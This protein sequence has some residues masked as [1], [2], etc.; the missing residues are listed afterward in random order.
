[1]VNINDTELKSMVYNGQEI[2]TWI[3][4]DIK[5]YNFITPTPFTLV[6]TDYP[7]ISVGTNVDSDLTAIE[8][9]ASRYRAYVKKDSAVGHNGYHVAKTPPIPTQGCNKVKVTDSLTEY[10]VG[11]INNY[12][13]VHENGTSVSGSVVFDI[14]DNT[15]ILTLNV[16]DGTAYYYAELIVTKVEFYYE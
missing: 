11:S 1:M 6:F 3:H 2:K 10:G 12:N 13:I 16:Q 4:N 8:T 9:T 7:L 5:V 14:S 15:F